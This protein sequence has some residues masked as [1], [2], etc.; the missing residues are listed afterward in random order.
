MSFIIYEIEETCTI[1]TLL[2]SPFSLF[3]S[4]FFFIFLNDPIS[5][6]C[7]ARSRSSFEFI[8]VSSLKHYK[9]G[10]CGYYFGTANWA[11]HFK[12][13]IYPN[14]VQ[15]SF[16]SVFS[17]GQN[18]CHIWFTSLWHKHVSSTFLGIL[19]SFEHRKCRR[20]PKLN[21]NEM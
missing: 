15:F 2:F 20:K 6:K 17:I 19:L 9:S 7:V 3:S 13:R 4:I 1:M 10:F 16:V 11:Y 14:F 12:F 5:S 8:G 18:S 21:R